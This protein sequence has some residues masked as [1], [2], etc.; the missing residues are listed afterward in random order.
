MTSWGP[1]RKFYNVEGPGKSYSPVN[2]RFISQCNR[3]F[4]WKRD[5]NTDVLS[6]T[7]VLDTPAHV[8]LVLIFLLI[9]NRVTAF[10]AVQL[11][12]IYHFLRSWMD[13]STR[14]TRITQETPYRAGCPSKPCDVKFTFC[15]IKSIDNWSYLMHIKQYKVSNT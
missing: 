7:F 3:N 14:S 6:L 11:S 2:F 9:L 1:L 13:S 8:N 10:A 12:K 5:S 4:K 15:F